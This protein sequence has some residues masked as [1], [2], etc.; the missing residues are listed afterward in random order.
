MLLS[1]HQAH[2]ETVSLWDYFLSRPTEFTNASYHK[3]SNDDVL[4]INFSDVKWWFEL[5]G[6]TDEEMNGLSN[7]LDKKFAQLGL[8]HSSSEVSTQE[9]TT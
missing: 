2:K 8:N 3:P 4:F 1:L 5:Y 6:R 7:S 9:S